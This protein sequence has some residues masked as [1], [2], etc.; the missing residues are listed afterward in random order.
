MHDEEQRQQVQFGVKFQVLLEALKAEG[1]GDEAQMARAYGVYPV[2]LAKWK[3]HL[4]EHGTEVF[5]AKWWEVARY[6]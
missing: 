6:T 4:L 2:N 1:K 3:H 5:G